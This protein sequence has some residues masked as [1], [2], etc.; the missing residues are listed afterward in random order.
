[1]IR[2]VMNSAT[3]VQEKVNVLQEVLND[4]GTMPEA[5]RNALKNVWLLIK[6]DVFTFKDFEA[7]IGMV[8]AQAENRAEW[9]AEWED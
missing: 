4:P 7:L 5:R 9:H 1:M 6:E 8:D 2:V 3:D